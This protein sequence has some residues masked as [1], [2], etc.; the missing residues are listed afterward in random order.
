MRSP[1]GGSFI[2]SQIR[3]LLASPPPL[4]SQPQSLQRSPI[5]LTPH[6]LITAKTP[7]EPWEPPQ[8]IQRTYP[9]TPTPSFHAYQEEK[10]LHEFKESVVEVYRGPGRLLGNNNNGASS[11]PSNEEV[12]SRTLTPRPFEMPDGWNGSF[13]VERL[14][15]AEGLWDASAALPSPSSSSSTPPPPSHAPASNSEPNGDAKSPAPPPST[16][17]NPFSTP[18]SYVPQQKDTIP[19]LI[20]ASLSAVDV[21]LRN[22]LL[23]CVIVTGGAS[24]LY[25]FTERLHNE[26]QALYPNAKVRLHAA[27]NTAERK[28]GAW[29]GGSILGSLGTFHQLWISRAEWEE[30]GSGIVE[31]RCK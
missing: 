28:Y 26:L 19:S 22:A 25:G 27:G 21:D 15:I 29:I 5:A 4:Q 8:A 9:F 1:L 3:S 31:R 13:G 12:A 18:N 11:G 16:P 17:P 7:V 30:H 20:S 14:R 10:I 24:L 2:S 6:Y 23:G